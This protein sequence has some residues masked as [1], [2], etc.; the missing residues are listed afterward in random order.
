MYLGEDALLI[1]V[2]KY[3]KNSQILDSSLETPRFDNFWFKQLSSSPQY[4][5]GP[6]IVQEIPF[7]I[8][9]QKVGQIIIPSLKVNLQI[10][11]TNNKELNDFVYSSSIMKKFRNI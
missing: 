7:L 1:L 6:Y 10:L 11:D 4:E 5:E 9:P 3:R 2:F 8:F